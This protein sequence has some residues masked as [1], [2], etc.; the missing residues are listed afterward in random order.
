M[1]K[2]I[3]LAD[4]KLWKVFYL[5]LFCLDSFDTYWNDG[6]AFTILS[7]K[8]MLS[9]LLESKLNQLIHGSLRFVIASW[10]MP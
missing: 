8:M 3:N 5:V 10:T 4:I 6:D 7:V 1:F 2:Y 9:M